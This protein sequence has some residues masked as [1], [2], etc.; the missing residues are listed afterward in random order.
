MRAASLDLSHARRRGAIA[1]SLLVA[2]LSAGAR[3]QQKLPADVARYVER[4]DLCD[5]FRGEEPYDAQRR[6]FLEQRTRRYCTG[7][8]AKLAGL[9][10]KYR[11]R[12]EVMSKLNE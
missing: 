8:D 4:R 11:G 9:K 3:A 5:H 10:G 7:A 6:K 1:L 12:S 2:V